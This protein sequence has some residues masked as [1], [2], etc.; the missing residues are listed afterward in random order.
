VPI[1]ALLTSIETSDISK[2]QI[3]MQLTSMFIPVQVFRGNESL[4]ACEYM[5]LENGSM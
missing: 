3:C 1:D 5:Y 2:P 4:I